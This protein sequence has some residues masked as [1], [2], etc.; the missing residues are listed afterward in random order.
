LLCFPHQTQ[1]KKKQNTPILFFFF[2]FSSS[3]SLLSPSCIGTVAHS[4]VINKPKHQK[5]KMMKDDQ[6]A[7]SSS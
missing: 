2:F 6:Q 4:L 3:S 5:V 1:P 7:A